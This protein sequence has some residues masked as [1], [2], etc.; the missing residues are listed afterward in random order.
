VD[1]LEQ[2]ANRLVADPPASP[3]PL[4]EIRARAGRIGRRR[5]RVRAAAFGTVPVLLAAAVAA[6][7]LSGRPSGHSQRVATLP[8]P[9]PTPAT[10]TTIAPGP[11]GT[12]AAAG[13]PS[14]GAARFL[15]AHFGLAATSL[16]APPYTNRLWS[17]TDSLRWK[18]ITPPGMTG[19]IDDLY[20][21]DASHLWAATSS[22]GRGTEIVWRST[23][24][25][26]SW[27][28]STP[29][30]GHNCSA[31]ST[32]LVRFLDSRHGWLVDIQANGSFASL[33]AT[34]DG[35]RTWAQRGD[36]L[37]ALGDVAF[38]TPTDGFLGWSSAAV[39]NNGHLYA[40]H[41]GGR[42]WASVPVALPAGFT[43][44][45][46]AALYGVPTFVDSST[47]VLPV[48]L[49]KANTEMVAWYRTTDGGKTW[50]LRSG[51][52]A[53]GTPDTIPP[54]PGAALTSV[55]GPNTWWM[56]GFNGTRWDTQVTTDGGAHWTVKS[57]TSS[58][59]RVY[60]LNAVNATTA[61]LWGSVGGSQLAQTTDGGA[62]WHPLKV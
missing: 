9:Q 58:S 33:L 36:Q 42:T 44:A 4:G 5:R 11:P 16:S 19:D 35:G 62:S 20:A 30:G 59:T 27:L 8:P 60:N 51:P 61:W 53:N 23:D 52:R 3:T 55:T 56:I 43:G 24:G 37:P 12:V 39:S 6:L 41:D 7:V 38:V 13:G 25:G 2:S 47:G 32:S 10:S 1:E 45:D 46:W 34:D 26:A 40:T 48:T 14:V 22:C 50:S 57:S 17:T 54:T 49:I 18:D 31:G 28:S 15:S 21:T 29:P